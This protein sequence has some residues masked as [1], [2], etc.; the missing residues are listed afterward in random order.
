MSTDK[1]ATLMKRGA[2]FICEK[3]GHLARDHKAYEEAEKK[4]GKTLERGNSERTPKK[5]NIEKIHALLSSLSPKETAQLLSMQKGGKKEKEEE[6]EE[7]EEKT[8]DDDEGF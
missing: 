7:A 2:C 8:D 3:P 6:V 4:K 1:R 5:N